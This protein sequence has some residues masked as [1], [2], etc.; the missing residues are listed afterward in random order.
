MGV[1]NRREHHPD[2]K[3]AAL[4]R[5]ALGLNLAA[6]N[7]HKQPR[8]RQPKPRARRGR[9]PATLKRT[10]DAFHVLGRDAATGI[11]DLDHGDLIAVVQGQYDRPLIRVPDRVGHQVDDDLAQTFFVTGDPVGQGAV[12]LDLKPDALFT[13]G[14]FKDRRHLMQEQAQVDPVAAEFQSPR[15]NPRDVEQPLNQTGQ[16]F[17]RPA[18]RRHRVATFQRD[19][20]VLFQN[21]GKAINR[22]QRR[23]QLMAEPAHVPCFGKVG[24][25]GLFLGLLQGAVGAF[26]RAYLPQQAICLAF[27]L[28]AGLSLALGGK[29]EHPHANPDHDQHGTENDGQKAVE[30]RLGLDAADDQQQHPEPQRQSRGKDQEHRQTRHQCGGHGIGETVTDEGRQLMVQPRL[31][32]AIIAACAVQRTAQRTDRTGVERAMRHVLGVKPVFADATFLQAHRR[33]QFGGRAGDIKPA[34]GYD[35]DQ[36]R[37]HKGRPQRDDRGQGMDQIPADPR[38]GQQRQDTGHHHRPDPDG[39]HVI[40]MRATELD[41]LGAEAEGFVDH[42]IRHQRP[43]P[44]QGDMGIEG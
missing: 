31:G 40:K 4:A 8:D 19:A 37:H 21:L 34:L 6:Q 7:F 35:R 44:R 12:G 3:Q 42:Q 43:D 25:L 32:L 13:R 26:V 18:D 15:L 2:A 29:D 24:G 14:F 23:A 41:S 10:P 30:I 16:M 33:S 20:R 5:G 11:G 9:G 36:G 39:V 17:G 27:C 28:I 22:V 1:G 38:I